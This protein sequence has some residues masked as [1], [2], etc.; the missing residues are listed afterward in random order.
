MIGKHLKKY[1][2]KQIHHRILTPDWYGVDSAANFQ[3]NLEFN[4]AKLKYY[5]Q[6]PVLYN[7]NKDKFRA[8]FEF[9][10][11]KKLE[12]DIYLGC[13]HTT[14]IGHLWENTWPYQVSKFTGNKIVNLGVGGKGIEV[15]F[16]NLSKYIKYFKVRNVFHFQPIYGRYC[17]PYKGEIGNVLIQNVNL[18][19]RDEDYIPWRKKYI[20]EELLN[21]EYIVY[22]HYRNI[23]SI[24]GLC[25]NHGIPYFH[26]F[27]TPNINI[28]EETIYARDLIHFNSTQLKEIANNFINRIKITPSGHNEFLESIKEDNLNIL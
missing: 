7:W 20:K 15:S 25:K 28:S 16:I 26:S 8:D 13:S 23:M 3:K 11:N 4:F 27:N 5:L 12:V 21:E 19:T 2:E 17:Y 9:I 10:P 24:E 6:N 22:N 14:G 18:K 1:L